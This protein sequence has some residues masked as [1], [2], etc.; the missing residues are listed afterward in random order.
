MTE[1]VYPYLA[2]LLGGYF[3]QD[4]YDDGDDDEAILA[5][6]VATNH[7]YDVAGVLAD[8]ARFV[9]RHRDDAADASREIFRPSF[10]LGESNEEVCRELA[11]YADILRRLSG[12]R[13]GA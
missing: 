5:D 7:D 1:D 11:T 4:C 12:E 10:S 3:H 2:Q 8:I 6:Y 9:H 13:P